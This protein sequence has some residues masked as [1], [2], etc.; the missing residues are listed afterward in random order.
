MDAMPSERKPVALKNLKVDLANP[1]FGIV[2]ETRE[3]D[4][5][6]RLCETANIRELWDSI[7]RQGWIPYEPIVVIPTNDPE[8]FTVI[9][10]NRRV[11]ALKTLLEPERLSSLRRRKIP[12]ISDELR[13][14][15]QEI[16]VT[17]VQNRHDADAYIGFR[18]INGPSSWGALAKAKF[19][20]RLF[21]S[22]VQNHD[23]AQSALKAV[24]DMLGD[25]TQSI[26]RSM[27]AYKVLEQAIELELIDPDLIEEGTLEFSHLYTMMPNPATRAFLGFEEGALKL[28]MVRE[29]PVPES[30]LE[31]L[32]YLMGWLFGGDSATAIAEKVIERQG[33]DRRVL[34]QVLNNRDAIDTLKATNDLK[35]ASD[36]AGVD[37]DDWMDSIFKIK[38]SSAKLLSQY[39]SVSRR[40]DDFKREQAKSA[41]TEARDS[42]DIILGRF[43]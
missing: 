40:L 17:I 27:V 33:T 4:A 6:L 24:T 25:T 19:G 3:E 38:A 42:L 7:A 22:Q 15:I 28:E 14:S 43:G 36:I 13:H 16:D 5:I 8:K 35:V 32:H 29:N 23:D 41:A 31:N 30:H 11:A 12:P 26:L 21:Q 18:H 10:G 2:D 34:Q 20:T 1:R 37:I 39:P 9:E